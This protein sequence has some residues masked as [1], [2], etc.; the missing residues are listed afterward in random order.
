MNNIESSVVIG[1]GPAGCTAALYLARAGLKPIFVTGFA[2]KGGQLT[3]TTIVENYPGF[4]EG[5]DGNEL[6]DKMI[7]QA[8][9]FGSVLIEHDVEKVDLSESPYKIFIN[10]RKDPIYTK[11]LVICTGANA[12]RLYVEGTHD[13]EFWQKGVSTCAVCD[14]AL[15]MFRDKPVAII[16]GGDSAMEEAL[17]MARYSSIVYIVNRSEKFKASI[18][19]LE[20]ARNNSKIK[21]LT[22]YVLKS[23]H[24][25]KVVSKMLL[26]NRI[27][28]E[29]R[30]I[31][32]AGI[33]FAIGH[34]PNTKFLGT[35]LELEASGC[36]KVSNSIKT[37]KA[38]VF[39][40]GDVADS[41]YRQAV[42]AAGDGCAAALEAIRY[43]DSL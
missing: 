30:E 26:K 6:M 25:D 31:E 24:G 43:I 20:R 40:A 34:I 4:P 36:V 15:S 1:S 2:S 35:E 8:E 33:F 7:D 32:L 27:T 29:D 17:Y 42:K 37:A 11:T 22:D 39:A 28:N 12:N 23:V 10:R 16:G 14:G 9:R 41:Q 21:I 18:I 19:M 38:G 3:T 5:I 13:N